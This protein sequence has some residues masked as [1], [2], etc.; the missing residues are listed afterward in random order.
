MS[1]ELAELE[2]LVRLG[3]EA[4]AIERVEAW[5]TT[6]IKESFLHLRLADL[7]EELGLAQRV[8]QELN[9][10]LRDDPSEVSILRRL[11]Q[12]HLDAG[13]VDRALRC[14]SALTQRAPDDPQAWLDYIDLLADCNRNEDAIRTC[15]EAQRRCPHKE[16]AARLRRLQHQARSEPEESTTATQAVLA[17]FVALFSGREGVY[18][19]QW[20]KSPQSTGYT[21]IRE[22]LSHRVAHNHLMGNFTIGTY[23]IRLDGTVLFAAID[24]DLQKTLVMR[25][26]PG[27]PEWDQAM[28][29]LQD[30]AL[31]LSDLAHRHEL[32]V[33]LE[34]SGGK[35]RH[36]WCFFANPTSAK[37]ARRL[38]VSWA[39]LAGPP[40]PMVSIELYPKQVHLAPDQLGNLIKLPLGVHQGS[41]RRAE[42]LDDH[43][44]PIE[45]QE[46]FLLRI[47]RNP[48]ERVLE[49][50]KAAPNVPWVEAASEE[51]GEGLESSEVAKIL[52][53]YAPDDDLELQTLMLRC[54]TLRA[55][56][57][58]ALQDHT[59]THDQ[60]QVV[61]HTLG[62]LKSGVEAVNHVLRQCPDV[63]ENY[64]LKSPLRG[65][66]MS[67]ARIRARI[68][69]TTC[70]VDCNCEFAEGASYPTPILHLRTMV[71][72]E[73]ASEGLSRALAQD[74]VLAL[75]HWQEALRRLQGT[76]VNL[77]QFLQK[78]NLPNIEL[79]EGKLE[80]KGDPTQPGCFGLL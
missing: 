8:V 80:L 34:D 53:P 68:P 43:G 56:R 69:Q 14:F 54:A 60:A 31:R 7:C 24:L 33:Y 67:C 75:R 22:P 40:P 11:A 70:R 47:Q 19:R 21:P 72:G 4:E 48:R 41:G 58:Q 78:H 18:A 25:S 32:H 76:Q 9:F 16:L 52:E 66:P 77:A 13:R 36:L 49:F 46:G 57:D 62:Y 35:G 30:Y 26:S 5:D 42:F 37:V 51:L 38:A 63:G 55:L 65:N 27:E 71:S 28:E 23:P 20:A 39:Q 6:L 59:L 64:H 1:A 79:A 45:D 3:K 74:Y 44:Q 2:S 73:Q 12:A 50:L 61:Q 10:A 15:Y 29:A 17:R